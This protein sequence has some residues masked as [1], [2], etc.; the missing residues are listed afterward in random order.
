MAVYLGRIITALFFA[1][2]SI[3]NEAAEWTIPLNL[4]VSKTVMFGNL[5]VKLEFESDRNLLFGQW[6]IFIRSEI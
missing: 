2:I 6:L 5:P 1:F 3:G 4:D